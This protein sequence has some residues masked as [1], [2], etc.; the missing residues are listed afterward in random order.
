[1]PRA[2]RSSTRARGAIAPALAIGLAAVSAVAACVTVPPADPPQVPAQG[3]V[4]VQDL[5]QP[6]VNQYLTALPPGGFRVPVRVTNHTSPIACRVFI[7][8]DPGFDNKQF[9]TPAAYSCPNDTLPSLDGGLTDLFFTLMTTNL[10]DPNV[11]HVIQFFVA[12]S[13]D[14]NVMHSPGDSLGADSVTWQ[15]TPN[16]PGNCQQFDGGDGA[17]PSAD[18][19]MDGLPQVPDAVGTPLL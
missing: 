19:P 8:F 16:G 18:A 1:M 14:A 4:I 3:P 12:Y 2:I 15:Y 6:P 5:V 9:A 13:F 11:C 17:F 7:D 10:V